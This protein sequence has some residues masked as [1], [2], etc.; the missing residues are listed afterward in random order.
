M[1]GWAAELR[2]LD[3]DQLISTVGALVPPIQASPPTPPTLTRCM[4][5]ISIT[6][7]PC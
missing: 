5:A 1:I 4:S 7:L 6:E 3:H 2:L